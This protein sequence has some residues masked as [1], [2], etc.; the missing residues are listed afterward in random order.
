FADV[1]PQTGLMTPA[2]L[3]DALARA[4]WTK[5][6]L[7]VHLAGRLCDMPAIAQLARANDAVIIEDACHALG[8]QDASGARAGGC[9]HSDAA[10]F[11][12]HPVKTIATGEGGMT[13]LNDP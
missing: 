13:T 10:V 6:V 5:A 1:D 3:E 2:T 7:P 8:S 11:S 12:F 9:V 4:G